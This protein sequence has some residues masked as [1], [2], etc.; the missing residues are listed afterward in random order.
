[1]SDRF[2]IFIMA[3]P[4]TVEDVFAP[5]DLQRLH[6]LGEVVIHEGSELTDHDFETLVTD[7]DVIMGTFQLPAERLSRCPKLKVFIN[8]EG[9]FLPNIDYDYCFKHG[10]RILSSSQVFADPVAEIGLAMAIDLGRGITEA[11]RLMR[12]GK[13][14]YG[15][16]ANRNARILRNADVG[17]IGF[18]DLARS[19]L[20]LLRPFNVKIKVFDPWVP[21]MVLEQA[22]CT[23]ATLEEVLKTSSFVFVL[24]GVTSEN[25][26]FLG[27]DQFAMMQPGSIFLLLSRAA[28]VD[29][30]AMEAA[31]ASGHVRVATDV[32]PVEPVPADA[33]VRRNENIL[34]SPHQAGALEPTLK[35]MGSSIVADIELVS[36]GLPPMVCK[37]A[38]PE[39]ATRFRSMPV[40][41]S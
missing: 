9:N 27:K 37:V 33:S 35:A 8:S 14:S 16:D 7:A 11:D 21:T 6:Q 12:Q 20:P 10:V 19:L 4:R 13:E 28:V 23:G 25:Q 26:H 29:F 5:A 24:A 3:H 38:Q 2:K 30:P 36:K 41:K 31:A 39:T 40:A 34:L 1:M 22:C 32:F 18:G 17:F 15:F